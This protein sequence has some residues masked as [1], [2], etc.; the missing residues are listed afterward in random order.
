[1]RNCSF[2]VCARGILFVA[3]LCGGARAGDAANE[4][5]QPHA[6]EPALRSE[7]G[8]LL[9]LLPVAAATDVSARDGD[10]SDPRTWKA[11]RLPAADA[12]VVIPEGTSVTL[13]RALPSAVRS[14][15]ID[16]TLRF[17]TD[18][19]T[20]L[21]VETLV[22]TPGGR[23]T[24]GT[25]DRPVAAGK[26]ARVTFADRGPIDTRSDPTLLGRGLIS[27]GTVTICGAP[28]TPHAALAG[29]ARR[30]DTTLKLARPPTNWN[31]GDRIVLTGTTRT[32]PTQD[33][34]LEVLAVAG[35]DVTVRP[36]AFDHVAPAEGLGAYVAHVSR[37]VTFASQNADPTRAG[38]VMFMHAPTVTLSHAAF[39]NLGRT[40]KLKPIDD[41]RLDDK[42]RATDGTGTNPRG[43]YAVH[44]HRTGTAPGSEPARVTGCA[45]V[46]GPGWGFVNHSSSVA[47]EDN[48]AFNVAGSAFVTEAGDET[49][50][51]RR[52]IAVRSTGSGLDEDARRKLQDFGHEGDGFWFQGGGVVVEDNVAAGQAAS[53]FIYFT[54]GLDQP[55]MGRARFG[56][57]NLWEPS[58]AATMDRVD[59]KDPD[60]VA[61][62]DSVPVI[63]VPVRSFRNNVAFACGTGFTTRFMSPKPARSVL[64]DSAAWNCGYGVRVRYTTNLDLV[65]LTLVSGPGEK[66]YCGIFGTLEGEQDIRYADLHVEGWPVGIH[67]PEAGHHVIE[68]GYWNNAK[69]ILIPTPL[70]R[71]R[72]VE[73]KGD[74]RFGTLPVAKGG[75]QPQ[76]DVYLEAAF[77]GLL[78]GPGGYRDPNVLFAPDV[79]E[80][81]TTAFKGRQLY[82]VEQAADFVPFRTV[83]ADSAAKKKLGDPSGSLPA[84]LLDKTNRQLWERYRLAL[85]GAVAP[86]D[87]VAEPRIHGLVGSP[88]AY[89]A[90]FRPAVFRTTQRQGFQLAAIGSGKK[91]VIRAQPV[92]LR[93]GWNLVTGLAGDGSTRSFLVFAGDPTAADKGRGNKERYEK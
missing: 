43:R 28:V 47:F 64:R 69:S 54:T 37:N 39:E 7:H 71:G 70:Q 29:P 89:P 13:D 52:N 34:V 76:Y 48:V 45:V 16:G 90:Q 55:G 84:E 18:R 27:H 53:G 46:N 32:T 22:V 77:A 87:A 68:G 75:S 58:W 38:H 93:G 62:A 51:F 72:S 83:V 31:P 67:V 20:A 6:H 17:A 2:P 79:T 60:R 40:D 42:G 25:P 11:G 65:N 36:L 73:I 74:V 80:L 8:I 50:T 86:P 91:E 63:A 49:G 88:L 24:V 44:F 66:P 12:D 5:A 10:W 30:G 23:L 82:Y 57:A 81:G 35:N 1:M 19:D 14:V 41:P 26:T 85:A 78:G 15:R 92:D 33:E 9:D 61:D 21:T 3:I 56:V 59:H 4:Q